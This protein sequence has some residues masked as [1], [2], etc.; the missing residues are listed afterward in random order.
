MI[1]LWAIV[2]KSGQYELRHDDPANDGAAATLD[3]VI[4]QLT[5]EPDPQSG[6]TVSYKTGNIEFDAKAIKPALIAEIKA[7]AE[8]KI[9]AIAPIWRQIND[10]ANPSENGAASRRKQINEVRAWSN[11]IEALID[12]AA[13]ASEIADLRATLKSW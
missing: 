3:K 7:I 5:R 9:L 2:S 6:E 13:S 1:K 10:L 12:A 11:E 4:W 8:R